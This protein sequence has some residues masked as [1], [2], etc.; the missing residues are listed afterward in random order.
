MLAEICTNTLALNVN[1]KNVSNVCSICLYCRR[2]GT[3]NG[4]QLQCQQQGSALL[5]G[6]EAMYI[7]AH[8]RRAT[9]APNLYAIFRRMF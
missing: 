2:Y 4:K 3:V 6:P 1:G 5:F 7:G 9:A 8:V